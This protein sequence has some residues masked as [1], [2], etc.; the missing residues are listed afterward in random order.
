MDTP[1]ASPLQP[2][3]FGA[4]RRHIP[5]VVACVVCVAGLGLAYGL[6]VTSDVSATASIVVVDPNASTGASR[7]ADLNYPANQAAIIELPSTS[8]RAAQLVNKRIPDAEIPA[9]QFRKRLDVE[10]ATSSNLIKITFH[11]PRPTVAAAGANAV[12]TVYRSD[13][14]ERA[15]REKNDA[16]RRIDNAIKTLD[17]RIRRTGGRDSTSPDGQ[18]KAQL[19]SRRVQF[20]LDASAAAAGG[21]AA[22]SPAVVPGSPSHRAA[23]QYG[24]F[25]AMAGLLPAAGASYLVASRRRRF[26]NRFDAELVLERPLVAEISD[27]RLERLPTDLP[28]FDREASSA[29]EGFRFIAS[30]LDPDPGRGYAFVSA[31]RG[32]GNSVVTA[33]VAVTAAGEGKRVMAIDGDLENGSLS[34]LFGVAADRPGLLQLLR[35]DIDVDGAAHRVE[36]V[37]GELWLMPG[38]GS[39]NGSSQ[40]LGSEQTADVFST[41]KERFDLVVVDCPAML[42]V[43]YAARLA[44][45]MDSTLVVVPHRS[46]VDQLEDLSKR[47]RLLRLPVAGFVYNRSPDA[48]RPGRRPAKRKASG[49][50]PAPSSPTLSVT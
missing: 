7:S 26:S 24:L 11:D 35:G 36:Q 32:D 20:V 41:L 15:E 8:T 31:S 13:L 22:A 29:A 48:R 34:W 43:A 4:M 42:E 23:L 39:P 19:Q 38:G 10:L 33:N 17:D 28:A 47:T 9:E 44:Y 12:A 1:E 45:H 50:R 21:I 40:L 3:V 5:L 37:P 49:E 2:T 18:A 14:D 25:G 27:F 16:L 6:W 30:I 46:D